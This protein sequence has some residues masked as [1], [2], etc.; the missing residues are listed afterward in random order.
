LHFNYGYLFQVPNAHLM[1]TNLDGNINTGYPLLGNPDLEPEKTVYFELGWTQVIN[2]GLRMN[3]TTYYKDIKNMVGSRE[4]EDE[5][6]ENPITMFTNADYGSCKGFDVALSSINQGQF[7]WSVNYSYMIAKGNASDPYEMY[8]DF[9]AVTE[10][11]RMPLPSREYPLAYDQR[12][13][14]T[15]VTDFRVS[16]GEKLDVL[17]MTL[18]DAWGINLLGRYG[19]GLAFTKTD[20]AGKRLGSLNGERLPYTLRF[21][22]RFNKN[23]YFSREARSFLSFFVEVEN[24]FDRRNVVSVY[25]ATGEP[26]EDGL[27]A[28]NVSDPNYAEQVRLYDLLAK[29]PQNYDHPR[30]IRMGMEFNF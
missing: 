22:L 27:I 11:E 13:N 10:E 19:S 15:A 20:V 14:L 30:Q 8:Y 16:R 1:F 24:L 12:H 9:I 29:N 18:P 3:V 28:S 2:D 5:A 26:D 7:N 23:F 6:S 17:G 4:V 21:D 25:S